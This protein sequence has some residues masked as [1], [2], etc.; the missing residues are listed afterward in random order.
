[1]AAAKTPTE[2]QAATRG[3]REALAAQVTALRATAGPGGAEAAHHA[4]VDA[5]DAL[6]A[7]ADKTS[8]AATSL[9]IC[10]SASAVPALTGV[11]AAAAVRTAAQGLAA[12]SFTFGAFLPA[13]STA[14]TRQATNGT[15]TKKSVH[16]GQGKLKITNNAATDAVI[17]LAPQGSAAALFTVYVRGGG[18]FTIS[19]VKDGTYEIFE[20]AGV[21]WDASTNGFSRDCVF[22]RFDKPTTFKTTGGSSTQWSVSLAPAPGFDQSSL[23]PVDP[24][25]FP[26]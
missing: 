24:G 10:G 15:Y 6:A 23:S 1:V 14:P 13:A 19:G 20:A 7:E 22:Q 3:L 25:Q 16:S 5:L 17:S 8:S 2:V 9:K 26:S 11:P 21:D 4:L 12:H 18:T